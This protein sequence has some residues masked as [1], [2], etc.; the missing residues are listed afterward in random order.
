MDGLEEIILS[1]LSQEE[2]ENYHMGLLIYGTYEI[3]RS[4]GEEREEGREGKQKGE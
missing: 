3:G 1:K 2:E 4:V